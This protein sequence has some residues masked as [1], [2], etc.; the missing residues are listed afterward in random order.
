MVIKYNDRLHQTMQ[1]IIIIVILYSQMIKVN[2]ISIAWL[3]V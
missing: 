2:N 1:I 3:W